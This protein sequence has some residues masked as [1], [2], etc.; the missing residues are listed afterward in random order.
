MPTPLPIPA[1]RPLRLAVVGLGQ[2]AELVLPTYLERDDVVIVGLCD[3][4][5]AQLAIWRE[6][7]PAATAT[8]S[9]DDLLTLDADVVDVLVPTPVH[10]EVVE[11][12]FRAG[13]HVQVQKPL[14]RDLEGAERMLAAREA[15]GATLRVLEDYLFFPPLVKMRD[16][17][18]AGEIGDPVSVHMKIVAT[19]RGGW[20]LPERSMRWQFE[21]MLD[22][23]GMMVFD[24][25]WHQLAVASW[26]FGPIRRVFAWLGETEIVPGIVMDA[27]S[28]L[29][30]EHESG[31]RAVLEISFAIDMYF[32]SSHYTGDERIEVTGT[33]GY[34]RT[35][36]ISAQGVQEPA[37]LLYR[38]GET[39]EYHDLDDRP[40]DAF[41]ASTA[42]A[43][44]FY[45]G[46]VADP[47]MGA[48]E[49]R[50]VLT[51]LLAALE[52]HRLGHAVDVG[53]RH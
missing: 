44:D 11:Q 36:R 42:H 46:E 4:D 14:A 32:R 15:S 48:E 37:V 12:V 43:L 13:F 10:A 53:A 34:V 17:I 27:P 8:T 21:Q 20:D 38:D 50:H 52:S 7:C 40:P 6:R 16:L 24:H 3:R 28:T 31:V 41:R 35:N 33:R 47:I 5:E 9:L 26:L 2:I 19:G 39:R 25:G 1:D 51:A 30:W 45:R 18:A 49:S 22:G 29:I 23:R